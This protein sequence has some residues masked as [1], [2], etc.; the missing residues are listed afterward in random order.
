MSGSSRGQNT[1]FEL[2]IDC[3]LSKHISQSDHFSERDAVPVLRCVRSFFSHLL[4][5]PRALLSLMRD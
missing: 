3:E 2:A 5:D 1:T 4:I